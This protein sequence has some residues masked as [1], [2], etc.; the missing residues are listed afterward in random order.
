MQNDS[1]KVIRLIS[2]LRNHPATVV[3]LTLGTVVIALSTF[4]DALKRLG[5]LMPP[6]E[7]PETARIKLSQMAYEYTPDSFVSSARQ[8]DVPTVKLFLSAG[9]NPN[10]INEK[11]YTALMA[12]ADEGHAEAVDALLEA[13]ADINQQ[14]GRG[15][16]GWR[17]LA[18]AVRSKH[19]EIV[20]ALLDDGADVE[21]INEAFTVA[22]A[23]GRPEVLRTLLDA[24]AD[25][26]AVGNTAL[27]SAVRARAEDEEDERG[28]AENITLLLD[29]GADVNARD[30]E[31]WTP[32]LQ[33]VYHRQGPSLVRI[34]LDRGAEINARCDC[35]G[36]LGGGWAALMIAARGERDIMRVLLDKGADVTQ[37]NN[38]GETALLVAVHY[39]GERS[40]VLDIVRELLEKGADVN[41]RDN[42][43]RT[44]LMFA[45]YGNLE[46]VSSELLDR[47]AEVDAKSVE[48]TTALMVAAQKGT[49][50]VASNLLKH[51]A[52]VREKDSHGRTPSQ[53]AEGNLQGP[54]RDQLML[55]LSNG[56]PR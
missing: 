49:V 18:L 52:S 10:V 46:D 29:H 33:G 30:E 56:R 38:R 8:G 9:M 23:T 53:L 51:G 37:R 48:G 20:R 21:S 7:S 22:G 1:R 14:R 36:Y 35:E 55:I 26:R 11:G 39:Y 44:A 4:T 15:Y 3:I 43:G 50:G 47:G 27:M 54:T 34:L 41:A 19:D 16:V 12:A 5:A 17:A 25:V 28:R 2:R 13:K 32:L 24:G 6:W 42:E 31:G 40:A 45:A